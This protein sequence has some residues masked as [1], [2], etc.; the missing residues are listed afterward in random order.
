VTE[1]GSEN[2][3][4][5]RELFAPIAETYDRYATLLSF[6]QDPRW[7]A[8]LASRLDVGPTDTVL[9]VACGTAAVAIELTRRT[10]CSV[11]GVDQ[12]ASM[13]GEGRRRVTHAGLDDQIT[14]Q[15]ARAEQLPFEDASFDGVTFTYLLRYV[16][17]PLAT[18]RELARVTRA[19]AHIAS[20]E[21]AVP[22]HP[23]AREAW[24]IYTDIGLPL[25]GGLISRGWRD[26]GQFLGPSIRKFD[27]DWP[28]PRVT[29]AWRQAGFKHVRSQ[30][31]S[32]GGGVVTWGTR[33]QDA[34]I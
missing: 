32:L 15:E 1:V 22:Q 14:L 6:G 30:R 9:D 29:E 21:F 25:A 13:L 26:V 28:L 7:R 2:N 11:V 23:V 18:L 19:G 24:R 17:D 3:R 34:A 8:F 5:A 33:G 27:R 20:L 31:L 12:S 10:G 4:E 16:Q